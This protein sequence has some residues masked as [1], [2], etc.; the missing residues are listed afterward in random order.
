M[1]CNRS[2]PAPSPARWWDWKTDMTDA[3]ATTPE[4]K[5]R[6]WIRQVVDFGAH[7]EEACDLP[8]HVYPA[9][10]A[11]ANG[12]VDRGLFVDGVLRGHAAFLLAKVPA[13]G[14]R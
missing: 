11:V 6:Q 10:L 5:N 2:T 4:K 8:D 7:D 12:E 14:G 1:T 9:A 3:P 13:P